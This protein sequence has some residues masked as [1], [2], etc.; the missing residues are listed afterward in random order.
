MSKRAFPGIKTG[1]GPLPKI[2]AT[3][4]ALALL[5]IVVKHPGDAATLVKDIA[6]F[7]GN[8]IDGLVAFFRGVT[9]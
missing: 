2:I 3:L 4:V 1:S 5:V 6:S 8:T 9:A 7:V